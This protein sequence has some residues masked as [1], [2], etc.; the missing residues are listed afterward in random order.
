MGTWKSTDN[1]WPEEE[2]GLYLIFYKYDI[3]LG[4]W[5]LEEGEFRT[6]EDFEG[7]IYAKKEISF[8]ADCDIARPNVCRKDERFP[9]G[10]KMEESP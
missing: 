10:R 5:S 3:K 1:C 6:E 9:G 7:E 2:Y 8:W 4:Y